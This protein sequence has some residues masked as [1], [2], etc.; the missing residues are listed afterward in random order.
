MGSRSRISNAPAR[1]RKPTPK[2]ALVVDFSVPVF[3]NAFGLLATGDHQFQTVV[4]DSADWTENILKEQ[5]A[6]DHG[7][8]EYDT[9][10]GPLSYGRGARAVLEQ[11][12]RR[13]VEA[14]ALP[15]FRREHADVLEDAHGLISISLQIIAPR[16]K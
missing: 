1:R 8:K 9:N 14:V 12:L 10:K 15:R 5:V 11:L 13:I 7:L 4:L 16:V 2:R 6:L 3:N